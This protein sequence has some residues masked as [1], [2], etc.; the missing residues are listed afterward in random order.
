[1]SEQS[2]PPNT[3]PLSRRLMVSFL[4]SSFFL[5]L[6]VI[7]VVRNKTAMPEPE[8]AKIAGDP[9]FT[10]ATPLNHSV[11]PVQRGSGVMNLPAH[12]DM[13]IFCLVVV[14]HGSSSGCW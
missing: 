2:D 13:P 14:V 7:L 5:R 6:L 1:M 8:L 11:F 3:Y 10:S 9:E 4:A 12:P